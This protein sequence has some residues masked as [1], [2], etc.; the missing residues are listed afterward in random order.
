MAGN[1][2]RF[3]ATSHDP[4]TANDNLENIPYICL[5]L[6]ANLA[7]LL[8]PVDA[9]SIILDIFDPLSPLRYG[10]PMV[11]LGDCLEKKLCSN[12]MCF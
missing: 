10:I 2:W 12:L 4:I 6:L 8:R 3:L 11:E 9:G 1:M 7:D 5:V